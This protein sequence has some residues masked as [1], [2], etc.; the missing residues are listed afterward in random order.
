MTS[1]LIIAEALL[2]A[3]AASA[4]A[5]YDHLAPEAGRPEALSAP[6]APAQAALE[7]TV[8]TYRVTS[9]NS[10]G[11]TFYN[12][13]FMGNNLA[14]R[15]P[16]L[17]YPV[18][19]GQEHLVRAGLWIGGLVSETFQITEAET[20]TTTATL[21]GYYGGTNL[22]TESE[23]YPASSEILERSILISSPYYDPV[24]AISEQDLICT[25]TD[26]HSHGTSMHKPLYVKVI[27]EILQFSYEPFDATIF[28]NFY[29]V[30]EHDSRA[31]FD[32]Y[33]GLYAEMAS[34]WK[35]GHEEWPPR[36]W[37]EKKDIAYYEADTLQ[38]V[39]EH[40]FRL[41][42]GNCPSWA[43]YCLLGTKPI[44][45][46]EKTV[47][48]NWWNWD[49]GGYEPETPSNDRERYETL[50]NGWIDNTAGCEAPNNDPVTLLSVG[51][52]GTASFIAEDGKEHWLLEAGDTVA[53]S[54]AFV[55]GTPSLQ[56]DPPRDAEEDILY[57]AAWA[58]MAYDMDF[59]I[60]MPPPSPR[61]H[62]EPSHRAITLW[63]DAS[64]LHFIDPRSHEEDFEGF[65]VY[66]SE[67]GKAEGFELVGE[68]DVRD[69]LFFDVGLDEIEAEEPLVVATDSD[70]TEYPFRFTIDGLKDGFKYWVS[71]TSFDQGSAD[72]KSLE[73]GLAQNRSFVIPGARREECPGN[74]VL[75]FPNPYRGDA[76][77]DEE[78][79]RDRYI[80][81]VG[82]PRRCKIRIYNL[83]GDLV[84]TIDFDASS[85]GATDVRGIYDPDDPRR[86]AADIPVLPGSMAAWDM[87]T[88]KDQAIASGLYIFSVEDLETG[89]VERG[90]FLI[91]K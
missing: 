28:M 74:R 19:S 1:K 18:G 69:G 37:F 23:F 55:C 86:P 33:V 61:L 77:W 60:P 84:H 16:S 89:R 47:S 54:F 90:K 50:A 81:F 91:L 75:V 36:G 4:A 27:Q 46:E 15:D 87:T 9:G 41:D 14:S 48:F 53:V 34:G 42:D 64:P 70:T 32:L 38:L 40:H 26:A 88:R 80:W 31:I 57:N 83:A 7:E 68:F 39:T 45:A 59:S 30:N 56:A 63:W 52:L 66:L 5:A 65:R 6:A 11:F 2:F 8:I 35:D 43:G 20:L 25:Y 85:Y 72:V 49:P 29:I 17:E 44:P 21:D 73:S 58:R 51:P 3:L 22:E 62:I 71:V 10:V 78:L 12:N 24:N 79:L 82:L 67:R 13:G 76:V